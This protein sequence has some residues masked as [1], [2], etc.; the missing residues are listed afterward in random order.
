MEV[1]KTPTEFDTLGPIARNAQEIGQLALR[2][3]SIA[4]IRDLEIHEYK[5]L[6]PPELRTEQTLIHFLQQPDM[7]IKNTNFTPLAKELGMT[8]HQM[9]NVRK[10]LDRTGIIEVDRASDGDLKKRDLGIDAMELINNVG[11]G[12]VTTD[13]LTK[14]RDKLVENHDNQM[15]ELL[16]QKEI[17]ACSLSERDQSLER[18]IR[19]FLSLPGFAVSGAESAT[20]M[21]KAL[22][23]SREE[24]RTQAMKLRTKTRIIETDIDHVRNRASTLRLNIKTL[25]EH[26]MRPYVSVELLDDLI[27]GLEKGV[28]KQEP[29]LY[30]QLDVHQTRG[31]KFLEQGL[32]AG[33]RRESIVHPITNNY[34]RFAFSVPEESMFFKAI[35]RKDYVKLSDGE[36]LLLAIGQ[37]QEVK[38]NKPQI[39]YL[40]LMMNKGL[41]AEKIIDRVELEE[42]INWASAEGYVEANGE[43]NLLLT[44]KSGEIINR[45]RDTVPSAQASW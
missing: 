1:L 34:L 19:Y 5:P 18:V 7:Q 42:T 20:F 45:V 4:G 40:E 22:S 35:E 21:K 23:L 27:D 10:S 11:A 13:V 16:D 38:S 25:L 36:K 6:S 12:F 43:N 31:N 28:H 3:A 8:T 30:D 29:K 41:A 24:Q 32:R 26:S 2:A 15:L 44:S 14:L 37:R 9:G 39:E 17:E 33:G